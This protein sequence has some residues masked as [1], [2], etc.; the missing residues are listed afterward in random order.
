MKKFTIL[1]IAFALVCALAFGISVNAAD[2][3]AYK[4]GDTVTV[5]FSLGDTM[6][7]GDYTINYNSDA[8]TFVK[9]TPAT[10]ANDNPEEGKVVVSFNSAEATE[11]VATFTAKTITADASAQVSLVPELFRNTSGNKVDVQTASQSVTVS[12]Q[13]TEN[14]VVENEV[15]KNE[16]VKNETVVN[17]TVENDVVENNVVENEVDTPSTTNTVKNDDDDK[18]TYDQTGANIAIVAV[19]ALAVV[20]GSAIVI[21]RK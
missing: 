20:L 4:A 16:V 12:A 21:K 9:V 6:R 17:D 13:P 10:S 18:K 3:T 5:K 1:T 11:V 2:N 14:E 8:L 15:T 7:N 19:I